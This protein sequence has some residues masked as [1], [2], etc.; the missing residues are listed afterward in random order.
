MTKG[1]FRGVGSRSRSSCSR[2][3]GRTVHHLGGDALE[4]CQ[5]VRRESVH[6]TLRSR[7]GIPQRQQQVVESLPDVPLLGPDEGVARKMPKVGCAR[8]VRRHRRPDPGGVH[9]FAV[10]VRRRVRRRAAAASGVVL[11]RRARRRRRQKWSPVN[12]IATKKT[13]NLAFTFADLA[14]QHDVSPRELPRA[15][16][17]NASAP[18]KSR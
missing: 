3:E 18:K 9:H 17:A 6:H 10:A 2:R 7:P 15:A 1:D 13:N 4:R 14:H 12:S 16:R 8:L 11:H 5:A